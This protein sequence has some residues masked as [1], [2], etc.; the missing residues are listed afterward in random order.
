MNIAQP[1]STSRV[2]PRH[3]YPLPQPPASATSGRR[4]WRERVEEERFVAIAAA[5]GRNGGMATVEDANR[6][7]L[8]RSGRPAS[9]LARQMCMRESI[10]LTGHGRIWLPLFQFDPHTMSIR[11]EVLAVTTELRQ[12]FDE[13]DIASWFVEPNS[14]LGNRAPV[15]VIDEDPGEVLEIAR[16]D[17]FIAAG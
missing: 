6:M 17:R 16:A 9:V 1:V 11:D 15:T 13:S 8:L 7:A 5:F 10:W 12:V 4:A 14:W 3:T 2:A